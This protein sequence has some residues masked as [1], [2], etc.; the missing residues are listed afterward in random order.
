M[1]ITRKLLKGMGL[2]D[3]QQDTI[4]EAHLETVNGLKDDISKYKGD[5]EKLP[6][7]QKELD[8]LKA[9]GDGGWKEKHDKV[10]RE[11]DLY[12]EAQ[13]AKETRA[14]KEKAYRAALKEMNISEKRMDTVVKAAHA[15][16]I[17][18][19]I[20]LDDSGA[21]KGADA[22]KESIKADWADFITVTTT[23]G[24]P[25]A[26]PPVNIGGSD[27]KN[28]ANPLAAQIAAEYHNNLYG[29]N[30]KE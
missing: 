24:A 12:K 13:T 10:K 14:A 27:N 11:F 6:A 18:D 9:A 3:E 17:I 23:Q 30:K 20:E 4:L 5:A 29:E 2:T 8:E 1:S 16:G 28:K 15:D 7:V 21:I 19:G 25:I 22:L 26:H